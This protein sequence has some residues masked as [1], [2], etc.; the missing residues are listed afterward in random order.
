MKEID[1]VQFEFEGQGELEGYHF[2]QVLKK[3]YAYIYKVTRK[4]DGASYWDVFERQV[5]GGD[6][7][8]SYPLREDYG[9]WACPYW[10]L[11][12]ALAKFNEISG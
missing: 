5:F 10:S 12:E 3:K 6:S 2:K 9:N 4:K 1:L 7:H 8:E 11:E